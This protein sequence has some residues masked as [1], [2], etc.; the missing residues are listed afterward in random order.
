MTG[1]EV[2][3]LAHGPT[4][5][6]QSSQSLVREIPHTKKAL[7]HHLWVN[8]FAI[9]TKQPSFSRRQMVTPTSPARLYIFRVVASVLSIS[10]A[11][12]VEQRKLV[13]AH[14]R[15]SLCSL[16]TLQYHRR[17]WIKS[18]DLGPS[19]IE[20]ATFSLSKSFM[21]VTIFLRYDPRSIMLL[22]SSFISYK[23]QKVCDD[24]CSFRV[25][26]VGVG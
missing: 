6:F 25:W 4:D 1:E 10:A 20:T 7:S 12:T 24:V 5:L 19:S 15:A 11:A 16:I 26:G 8:I 18:K 23:F 14:C 9:V 2:R 22:Y 13:S 17:Y 21:V 3:H